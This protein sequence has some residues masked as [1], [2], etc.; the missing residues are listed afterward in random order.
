MRV[1]FSELCGDVK[2]KEKDFGFSVTT[3]ITR[4]QVDCVLLRVRRRFGWR[5][6]I[7]I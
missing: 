4:M 6:T 1:I 3:F 2:L 7:A 5:R